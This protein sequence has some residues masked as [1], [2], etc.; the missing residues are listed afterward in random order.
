MKLMDRRQGDDNKEGFSPFFYGSIKFVEIAFS[1]QAAETSGTKSYAVLMGC[2]LLH[3]S[4][5]L[6]NQI[7][8]LAFIIY[9]K[10]KR[11]PQTISS[12]CIA[13]CFRG[14]DGQKRGSKILDRK[15]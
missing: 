10:G 12:I 15:F 8:L 4:Y 7:D 14:V 13:N 2:A 6:H 5:E 9:I 1:P 3:P 11:I